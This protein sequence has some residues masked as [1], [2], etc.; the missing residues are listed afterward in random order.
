MLDCLKQRPLRF[1]QLVKLMQT[2]CKIL[3]S[4]IRVLVALQRINQRYTIIQFRLD[5][6]L[7]KT[8][9]IIA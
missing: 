7:Q 8:L 1:R 5:L 6:Y 9:E 4:T 2:S 3:K